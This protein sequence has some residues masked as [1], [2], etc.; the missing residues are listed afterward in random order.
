[1]PQDL[2]RDGLV[3]IV[4]RDCPTCVMTAQEAVAILQPH[5]EDWKKKNGTLNCWIK[6]VGRMQTAE[7]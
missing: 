2:P 7:M 5:Y 6:S 1:M 4:K 3:A